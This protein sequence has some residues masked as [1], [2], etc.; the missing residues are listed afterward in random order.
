MTDG[1]LFRP[2][3][4]LGFVLLLLGIFTTS[5]CDQYWQFFLAQGVCMGLG[6]GCLF[7]PS[8]A[9]I[10]TYFDKRR[11]LA[12]GLAAAGSATGGMIYPVMVRQLL[13]SVGFGWT[14]RAIGFVQLATLAIAGL[15]LKS[16][17]PPRKSGA[18]VDW[19]AFSEPDYTAYLAGGFMVSRKLLKSRWN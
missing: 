12:M 16:R 4:V 2:L 19:S 13:P 9:V 7:C 14:I 5:V 15:F 6:N 10:S 1:G 8:M 11:A 18:L 17:L 3:F